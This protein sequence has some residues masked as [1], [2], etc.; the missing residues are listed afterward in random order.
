MS[1]RGASG[2]KTWSRRAAKRWG[3]WKQEGSRG[4]HRVFL[5]S[6]VTVRTIQQ[7]GQPVGKNR[8]VPL[9]YAPKP[10]LLQ[11]LERSLTTSLAS[12]RSVCLRVRI[13]PF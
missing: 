10:R 11:D 2:E 9:P 1:Y 4:A 7:G 8:T 6:M 13:S 12:L 3:Q 5:L